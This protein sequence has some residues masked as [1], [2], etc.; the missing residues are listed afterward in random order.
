[1]SGFGNIGEGSK[2]VRKEKEIHNSFEE[3]YIYLFIVVHVHI[4]DHLGNEF[5]A[6]TEVRV[7]LYFTL[8]VS[9]Y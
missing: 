1:M 5:L 2:A 9:S 3:I 6:N 4:H 7:Y 8:V